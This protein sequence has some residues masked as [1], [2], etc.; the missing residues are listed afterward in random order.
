MSGRRPGLGCGTA[1]WS[2]RA[3]RSDGRSDP[4]ARPL[5]GTSKASRRSCR[6]PWAACGGR[7]VL[8]VCRSGASARRRCAA[9]V[10]PSASSGAAAE[11]VGELSAGLS[12]A[13]ARLAE[14][15]PAPPLWAQAEARMEE[16]CRRSEVLV[17]DDKCPNAMW[18]GPREALHRTALG[19]L[20]ADPRWTWMP[21]SVAQAALVGW[22]IARFGLQPFLRARMPM[23]SPDAPAMFVFVKTKCFDEEGGRRCEKLS[24]A[25]VRRIVSFRRTACRSGWRVL[26]RAL[27]GVADLGGFGWE[28][29]A[30]SEVV[31]RLRAG[32]AGLRPCGPRCRRCGGPAAPLG[33]HAYDAGQAFEACSA[34]QALE[35]LRAAW[36]AFES[37]TGAKA[38]SVARCGRYQAR[39]LSSSRR[40]A[41]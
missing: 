3:A 14:Q 17:P 13:S 31:P 25:C 18:G 12:A 7:S 29:R 30:L 27:Q 38:V 40:H 41:R 22:A 16:F 20:E 11:R 8:G 15:A 9:C 2:V 4:R 23:T 5:A 10:P 28:V 33:V 37:R 21:F 32:A 39:L 19:L 26:S 1:L 36:R 6:C 24:H 34:E 35:G